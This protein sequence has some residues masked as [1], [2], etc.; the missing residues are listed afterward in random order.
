MAP[1]ADRNIRFGPAYAEENVIGKFTVSVLPSTVPRTPDAST[2]HCVLASALDD[3]AATAVCHLPAS[4]I[5]LTVLSLEL[6][7]R[8]QEFIP[9]AVFSIS[10]N[11]AMTFWAP[12]GSA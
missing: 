1:E 6:Y 9:V 4:V 11:A 2:E 10:K 8:K 7:S 3:P 5:R 12:A